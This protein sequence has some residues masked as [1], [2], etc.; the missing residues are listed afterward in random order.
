SDNSRFARAPLAPSGFE[1]RAVALALR[2]PPQETGSIPTTR[3]SRAKFAA[4][5]FH[6]VTW[7]REKS[8]VNARS[9]GAVQARR[10]YERGVA[11]TSRHGHAGPRFPA[12]AQDRRG[13]RG[14]WAREARGAGAASGWTGGAAARRDSG[15][16]SFRA[17]AG[18]DQGYAA[19]GAAPVSEGREPGGRQRELRA[20]GAVSDAAPQREPPGVC[21]GGARAAG[22][23]EGAEGFA[24]EPRHAAEFAG[25]PRGVGRGVREDA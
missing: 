13:R 25:R 22:Q 21:G 5:F 3:R 17:A 2:C 7:R 4:R 18:R 20:R 10:L 6:S 12:G 1:L 8:T 23:G 16:A 24:R 9:P 11:E 14:A 19:D 15:G